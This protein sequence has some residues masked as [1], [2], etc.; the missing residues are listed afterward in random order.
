MNMAR[1]STISDYL[2]RAIKF[3]NFVFNNAP[4]GSYKTERRSTLFVALCDLTVE[5]HGAI[6]TL[7]QSEQYDGSALALLRPLFETCSRAFWTLYCA[8]EDE[9]A[10]ITGKR[11]AFPTLTACANAIQEY[12]AKQNHP[13]LFTP[14]RDYIDQLHGFTHSGIEQLQSRIGPGLIVKPD[15]SDGTI[16]KLLQQATIWMASVSIA[17][18]HFIEGSGSDRLTK[19]YTELFQSDKTTKGD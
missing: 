4:R 16:C 3:H 1:N 19:L 6:I 14:G 17:Q 8:T 13:N 11:A 2:E 5:H 12:F 7:I 18:L 15:Y 9:L 10:G